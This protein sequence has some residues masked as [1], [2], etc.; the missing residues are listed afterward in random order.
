M[1]GNDDDSDIAAVPGIDVLL[2]GTNDLTVELG[3]PGQYDDP[4]VEAA[5]MKVIAAAS[6]HGV[7]VG[8]GGLHLRMDLVERF[9]GL[10]ARYVMA[11]TDQPLLQAGCVANH[12]NM[13][14]I[15][16]RMEK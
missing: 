12:K 1:L 6:K 7:A 16:A 8:V 11:G 2:V 14:A 5:Y 3:I 4:K 10:G 13:E 9:L 15:C